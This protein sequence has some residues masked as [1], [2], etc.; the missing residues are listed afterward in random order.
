MWKEELDRRDKRGLTK[1]ENIILSDLNLPNKAVDVLIINLSH[2][3]NIVN[4]Y[5]SRNSR[6]EHKDSQYNIFYRYLLYSNNSVPSYFLEQRLL[7]E[8]EAFSDVIEYQ[9]AHSKYEKGFLV[10]PLS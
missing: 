7:Y 1:L 9:G 10:T 3:E 8:R 2:K 6:K 5:I 4:R